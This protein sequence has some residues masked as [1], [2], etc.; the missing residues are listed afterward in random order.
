MAF[1]PFR[2]I[3]L[4]SEDDLS[5]KNINTMQDN[6]ASSLIQ[7]LGKDQLDSTVL[8][9]IVLK[10]G[11]IN[12]VSH[13]LGRDISGYIPVRSHGGFPLI[14]DLQ[15]TNPSPNLLL[16]LASATDITIDLLVF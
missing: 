1:S 15:D 11:V 6:I 8:K 7:L 16:Y 5:T 9:N 12:K 14:Y 10:A 2:K 3:R 4:V 13:T